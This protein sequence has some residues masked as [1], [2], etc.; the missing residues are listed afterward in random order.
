MAE[1]EKL[2]RP[3][4]A[5]RMEFDQAVADYIC[6]RFATEP[7]SLKTIVTE[8][9]ARFE[10]FPSVTT[11]YRWLD[12][13]VEFAKDYARAKESQGD[14]LA[15][16]TIEIADD[17]KNDWEERKHF[18]GDDTSPQ[19]NGEAI[20]RAKLRIDTRKWMA[21]HL[22][23]KKYGDAL[24]VDQTVAVAPDLMSLLDRVATNGGRL[25]HD[26]SEGGQ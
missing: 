7:V 20:A 5:P 23:P 24:K 15:E 22:R 6:E 18:A 10:T 3:V 12:E 19:V 13:N 2:K 8:G 21:A 25:A 11:V 17:A 4:G 9:K 1:Q 16:D 14:L 26:D